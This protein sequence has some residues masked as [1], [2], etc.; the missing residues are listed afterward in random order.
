MAEWGNFGS[1]AALCRPPEV[2]QIENNLS[3]ARRETNPCRILTVFEVKKEMSVY[4]SRLWWR[5]RSRN[6]S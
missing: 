4:C 1:G 3:T 5:L 2:V 6:P